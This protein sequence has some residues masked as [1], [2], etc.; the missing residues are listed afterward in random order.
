MTHEVA[1]FSFH[2]SITPP[3]PS[4][5]NQGSCSEKL[6]SPHTPTI[7]WI[8]SRIMKSSL[9]LL[10]AFSCGVSAFAPQSFSSQPI[11]TTQRSVLAEPV[12]ET[13]KETTVVNGASATLETPAAKE[14]TSETAA[15]ETSPAIVDSRDQ[16]QP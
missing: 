15:K 8:N 9:A 4:A 7:P 12:T 1:S 11:T 16:L 2:A 3:W 10:A 6:N 14:E 13:V 5:T